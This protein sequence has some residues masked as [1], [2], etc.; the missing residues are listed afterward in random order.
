MLVDVA[1]QL[2]REAAIVSLLIAGPV[3]ACAVVVGLV[4]SVLQAVTQLQDQT[5]GFVPK[6]VAMGAVLVYVFP[7]AVGRMTVYASD[8]FREVPKSLSP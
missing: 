3:L 8:V 6:I 2:C 4:V 1:V 7:W 5:L